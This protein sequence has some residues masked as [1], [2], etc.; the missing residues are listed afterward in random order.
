MSPWRPAPHR[1]VERY[2]NTGRTLWW[3][4]GGAVLAA[5][6]TSG[7]AVT[8]LIGYRVATPLR[9]S[10]IVCAA[11]LLLWLTRRN[12]YSAAVHAGRFVLLLV[13]FAIFWMMPELV[14]MAVKAEPHDVA[15]YSRTVSQDARP[16]R[17]I[18]WLLFDELSYDQ[19]FEHRQP[20][21]PL[22]NFDHLA[23]ES[24]SFSDVQPAGYYTELI[25]PSLLWGK[26]IRRERSD[27][28]GQVQVKTELGW[29]PYPD[30]RT[31]FADANREGLAGWCSGVVHPLLPHLCPRTHVVRG[32][33]GLAD[34]RRLFARKIGVAKR[35]GPIE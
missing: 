29:Q 17:R 11:G 16:E 4:A 25:M 23:S 13:G 28:G 22:P 27:L 18:V 12:W 9:V 31:L 3:T 24:V 32:G 33:P 15:S 6:A 20:G 14:Y 8:G 5:K 34:S 7:L 30:D 19:V 10:G 2:D 1:L 35:C 21:I 26:R